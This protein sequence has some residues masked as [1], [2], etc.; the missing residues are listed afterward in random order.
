MAVP[1]RM[2]LLE[3]SFASAALWDNTIPRNCANRS[4]SGAHSLEEC[5]PSTSTLSL[6]QGRGRDTEGESRGPT[7]YRGGGGSIS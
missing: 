6:L 3:G 1:K 7:A 5:D 2:S 4:K